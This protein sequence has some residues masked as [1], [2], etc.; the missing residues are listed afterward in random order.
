MRVCVSGGAPLSPEVARFFIGLGLPL[1]EGYGLTEASP[2]ISGSPPQDCIPGSVGRPL[3][4]VEVR[5]GRQGELLARG[6]NVMLGYWQ[7][8]EAT[9]Q[10]IDEDGWLHTGD[11]AE[12]REGNIVIR[13][14]LKEVLVTSTG[15]K[16]PPADMEMALTADPLFDQAIVIGEGRP[17]LAAL[18][19]LNPESWIRFAG[20]LGLEHSDPNAL[21]NPV[22]IKAALSR[23]QGCLKSFPGYAQVRA[24]QLMLKPWTVDNGLITPTMKV[25][26]SQLEAHFADEIKHLYRGREV[27]QKR[28]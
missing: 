6:P 2:V 11:V 20:N 26:R 4:D 24:V 25:K 9:R 8:P 18:L 5:I 14:R 21:D 13:G 17:Y 28:Q 12:I 10:A 16:V 3:A 15:E 22:A 7:Q 19:V 1:T 23:V 27:L